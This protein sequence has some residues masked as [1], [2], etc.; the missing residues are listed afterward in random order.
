VEFHTLF[1]IGIT[2]AKSITALCGTA[3]ADRRVG[4]KAGRAPTGGG[5]V[6]GAVRFVL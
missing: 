6:K 1:R 5:E 3:I 2:L 4:N